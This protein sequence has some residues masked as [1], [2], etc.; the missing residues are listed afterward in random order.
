VL[1]TH[2]M[3]LVEQF[4]DRAMMLSSGDIKLIG[5][6]H[7]V[8]RA[9]LT[10][11][12]ASAHTD[13]P[14]EAQ[15]GERVRLRGL[16]VSN[17]AGE[18]VEALEYGERFT[19]HMEIEAL[20]HVAEPGIA[21]WFSTEDGAR[22]FSVGA[23]ENEGA[24]GDLTAGER[25]EFSIAALNPLSAGRYHIGCTV[26]RGSAGLDILM[27]RD[28]AADIVSYGGGVIGLVGLDYSGAVTR[29]SAAEAIA[30]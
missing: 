28:R 17:D 3:G 21:M 27:H 20:E 24:L 14:D 25:L 2:A 10:E 18:R 6:P 13:V 23:R 22:V 19:V 15:P 12:F 16:W 11:N 4:C 29:R 8:G 1:V 30:R 5:A 7:E 26:V 9:Y